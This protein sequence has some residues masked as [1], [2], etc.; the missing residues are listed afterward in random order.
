MLPPRKPKKPK[1]ETRWRSQ[2]HLG[3]VRSH[4]CSVCHSDAGIEAAHVRIGSGAGMGQKPD[5]WRAVSL[6]RDCH[7]KQHE[8]GERTFW[9]QAGQDVEVLIDAFCRTSPK[10]SEIRRIRQEREAA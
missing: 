3:F 5:D 6:C 9:Q 8:V 4:C 7:R 2:A 1:A 10:A